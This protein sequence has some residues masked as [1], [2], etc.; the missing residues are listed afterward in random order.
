MVS[1]NSGDGLDIEEDD[2]GAASTA[3]QTSSIYGNG[4]SA[5]EFDARDEV[6]TLSIAASLILGP[7]VL[8]HVVQVF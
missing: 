8:D 5:I 7:V 4:D 2:S 6:G 1:A 3:V